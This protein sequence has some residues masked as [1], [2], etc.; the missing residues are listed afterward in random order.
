MQKETKSAA[1]L[2]TVGS[3]LQ[4]TNSPRPLPFSGYVWL[5]KCLAHALSVV[6]VLVWQLHPLL[7]AI[8]LAWTVAS[9]AA[10][11]RFQASAQDELN[12]LPSA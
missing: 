9:T 3:A 10:V 7:L 4:T 11:T 8:W 1:K 2:L 6:F 5:P 12:E